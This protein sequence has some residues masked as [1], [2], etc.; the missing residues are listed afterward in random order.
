MKLGKDSALEKLR[1]SK[2][3]LI[4][5][6]KEDSATWDSFDDK[7][8]SEILDIYEKNKYAFSN[9]VIDTLHTI[10]VNDAFDCNILKER[11][12]SN[13]IIIIDSTE[14]YI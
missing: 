12:T 7:E 6:L 1:N 11:K 9:S 5:A 4:L 3:D 10:K 8:A 14:L 13:G 2:D